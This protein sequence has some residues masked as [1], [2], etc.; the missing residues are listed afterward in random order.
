MKLWQQAVLQFLLLVVQGIVA[1]HLLPAQWHAFLAV[2]LSAGQMVLGVY[3]HLRNP[4]G[5][6]AISLP[7][8]QDPPKA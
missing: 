5:S 6:P 3:G 4:D 8:P 7:K 1:E 2:V